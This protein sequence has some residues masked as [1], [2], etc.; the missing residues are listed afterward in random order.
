MGLLNNILENDFHNMNQ[1]LI[2]DKVL[3]ETEQKFYELLENYDMEFVLAMESI[4]NIFTT[5][6]ISLAYIQGLK[7]FNGLFIDLKPD[8]SVI[9]D[10]YINSI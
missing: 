6:G 5:R 3:I 8:A 10:E 4:F 1:T 2:H 9:L 7:D